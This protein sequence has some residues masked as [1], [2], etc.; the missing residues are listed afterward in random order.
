MQNQQVTLVKSPIWDFVLWLR[1]E[2]VCRPKLVV[3]LHK[4]D[5]KLLVHDY[6]NRT[7]ILKIGPTKPKIMKFHSSNEPFHLVLDKL[8]EKGWVSQKSPTTSG[9]IING[10]TPDLWGLTI[11]VQPLVEQVEVC[12]VVRH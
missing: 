10:S 7:G 2:E 3:M 1:N 9:N 5:Y 4:G 11:K 6:G 12:H 8:M